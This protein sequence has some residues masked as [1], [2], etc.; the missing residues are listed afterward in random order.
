MDLIIPKVMHVILSLDAGGGAERLV[1]D[2]VRDAAF[3]PVPPVVC[4]L[5]HPGKLG[6]LLQQEGFR[7][8]SPAT[9]PGGL[10]WSLVPW[11]AHIIRQECVDVVHAHQYTPMFYSVPAALAAGRKRVIYTEHGRLYPDLPNWKR[12]LCN[13]LL[14]RGIDQI[15]SISDVTKEAMVAVDNFAEERIAVVHNG[16]LF[17]RPGAGFDPVEKRRS[18]G[19]PPSHRV[20]GTAAR[21][22]RI[23]NLPMML[24][25]FKRVLEKMPETSL[26]IAGRGSR[27]NALKQYAQELGIEKNVR[28]LGL[29]DDL[30]EIYPLFELFLL[31]SF[32]EG[33][34]VTLL[35]AMSHGVAPIATRVGGNPEV[36]LEGETGL[37]VADDDHVELGDKL[38]E[39]MAVPERARRMGEAARGWVGNHFSFEKMVQ[40]YLRLYRGAEANPDEQ[41][42]N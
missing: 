14:A 27:E 21:L 38:L 5:Y 30:P 17:A 6:A 28:F 24:R 34:S 7:V 39:L 23:K 15:V 41:V 9:K 10:Q 40:D 16:V 36:V 25:G 31:T 12:R 11:L 22:E 2:L 8:Y 32:S 19:I 18:L 13:P 26:L 35:E 3:S 33:I 20:I 42:G 29:R 1:Y 37:L 4:C